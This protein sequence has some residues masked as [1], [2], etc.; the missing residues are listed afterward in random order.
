MY[1]YQIYL[2][3]YAKEM[4]HIEVQR[5]CPDVKSKNMVPQNI[6]AYVEAKKPELLQVYKDNVCLL[7]I[8]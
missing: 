1:S 6:E 3:Y 2:I 8:C 7:L 4:Q 5:D